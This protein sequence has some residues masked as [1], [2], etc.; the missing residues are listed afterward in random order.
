MSNTEQLTYSSPPASNQNNGRSLPNSPASSKLDLYDDDHYSIPDDEL[1]SVNSSSIASDGNDDASMTNDIALVPT[2]VKSHQRTGDPVESTTERKY[3]SD[4]KT[5]TSRKNQAAAK[6]LKTAETTFHL[7]PS[8]SDRDLPHFRGQRIEDVQEALRQIGQD[9]LAI[10]STN[11]TQR[12]QVLLTTMEDD[13]YAHRDNAMSA[14]SH[15]TA[16]DEEMS[17]STTSS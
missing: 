15:T 2:S 7:D 10:S 11:L 3:T 9:D 1:R 6:K 13:G 16:T 8:L 17:T 4:W 5:I 14:T 12:G